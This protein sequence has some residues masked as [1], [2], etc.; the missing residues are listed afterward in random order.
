MDIDITKVYNKWLLDNDKPTPIKKMKYNPLI[1]IVIP[2][3]NPP[4]E[5]LDECIKSII[6]T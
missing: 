1:S 3:Y 2:V 4:K 5:H 6:K